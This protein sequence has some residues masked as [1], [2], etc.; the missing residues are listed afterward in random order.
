MFT[1]PLRYLLTSL[2]ILLLL[3]HAVSRP[4]VTSDNVSFRNASLPLQFLAKANFSSLTKE[5]LSAALGDE[6]EPFTISI[7]NSLPPRKM[8]GVIDKIHPIPTL[9][10]IQMIHDGTNSIQ[11]YVEVF[12]DGPLQSPFYVFTRLGCH[13]DIKSAVLHNGLVAMTYSMLLEIYIALFHVMSLRHRDFETIFVLS[14]V[15]GNVVSRPFI[16]EP[17]PSEDGRKPSTSQRIH[18]LSSF[19]MIIVYCSLVIGNPH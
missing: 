3:D 4:F 13:L 12:G 5:R 7:P 15:D 9:S 11:E 6:L 17:F 2:S 16:I 8:V 1:D 18:G 19:D 10:V 14:G